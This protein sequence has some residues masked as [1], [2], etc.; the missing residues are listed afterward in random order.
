MKPY[1]YILLAA[2]LF[3]NCAT[4]NLSNK[5]EGEKVKM[6]VDQRS[7][8]INYALLQRQQIPTVSARI[9]KDRDRGLLTAGLVTQ[10][11]TAGA[12]AV[13]QLIAKENKKYMA[14]YES[15]V[16]G[17]FFYDQLS[18]K[19]AFDPIGMQF[20][21]FTFVRTFKNAKGL[22]D[23][24]IVAHFS[25]DA[26]SI[27]VYDIFNNSFFR[28]K[29]D[30]I[31]VRYAKAKMSSSHWYMPWTLFQKERDEK[32]H[33]DFEID[34]TTNYVNKQGNIFSNLELGKFYLSLRDVPINK[35]AADYT[36]Y[37]NK[38]K[39]KQLDGYSFVV[40]RSF[41]YYF[42]EGDFRECYSRG[43][44]NI[45]VKVKESSKDKFVDKLIM[46]NSGQFIDQISNTIQNEA[47]KMNQ[48]GQ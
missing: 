30:S 27:G 41:G 28:I 14:E 48:P 34:F 43:L 13:K 8:V 2:I 6:A 39:G 18:V 36:E 38:L 42:H 40:P 22:L 11:V 47:K 29:L 45:A 33:L 21:G 4:S 10:A 26:D 3:T 20:A 35:G 23:T 15:G 25:L 16:T 5:R 17:L 24:A 19:S 31:D 7:E 44:Y 46:S 1:P 12:N 32:L 37:Y 9:A